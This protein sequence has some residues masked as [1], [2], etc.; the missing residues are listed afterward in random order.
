MVICTVVTQAGYPQNPKTPDF[1][2]K[3]HKM[4]IKTL[5]SLPPG[6]LLDLKKS[7]SLDLK[8]HLQSKAS[9]VK[10]LNAQMQAQLY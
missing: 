8:R 5:L 2:I 1:N 3:E 10:D 7:L 4:E 9:S 6:Q